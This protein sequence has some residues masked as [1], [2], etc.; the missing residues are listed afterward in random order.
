MD[1]QYK[2]YQRQKAV[3]AFRLWLK[4]L[5]TDWEAPSQVALVNNS[6]YQQYQQITQRTEI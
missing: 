1:E 4:S 6:N 5:A 3:K 2:H